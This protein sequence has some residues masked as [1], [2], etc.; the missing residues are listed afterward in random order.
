MNTTPSTR[1]L[2]GVFDASSMRAQH[3]KVILNVLWKEREASRA[4]LAR[5]TGMS[6]STV[7]AIVAELLETGLIEEARTGISTGGRRPIVLAFQE[8][9]ALLVGVELGASHVSVVLTDLYG[10]ERDHRDHDCPVRDDPDAALRLVEDSI[11]EMLG[12]SHGASRRLVGIGVAAPSPIDPR[13][14][15]HLVPSIAPA[16]EHHDIV[17]R[18]SRRFGRPVLLDNDANLGALAERWWTDTEHENLAYLKVATGIGA[19]LIVNGKIFRGAGGIAGEIGHT[20]IDPNGPLCMCGLRGCLTTLVGSQRLFERVGELRP[21]YPDTSLPNELTIESLVD[22]ALAGDA[23]AQRIIAS[24]GRTLG[25]GVSNLLNLMNPGRVVI[26]GGITR[27]GALLLGPLRETIATRTLA[28]SIAHT[29]IDLSPLGV[30][31]IAVGAATLVLEHALAD[32]SLFEV[33]NAGV[34]A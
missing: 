34:S 6:R 14:P 1:S 7:S 10:V 25:I 24:A 33:V 23:L 13:R 4:D 30:H 16:W 19:G 2:A 8:D 21:E 18:L 31:G 15:G 29:E 9:A 28:E 5:R 11:D 12:G 3:R 17:E 26:G 20:T 22:A 27:A 32:P